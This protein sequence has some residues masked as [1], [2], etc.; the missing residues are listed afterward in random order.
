MT[1]QS[2]QL[3]AIDV[4]A[5]YRGISVLSKVS[6]AARSGRFVAVLGPNGA[7]KSTLIRALAGTLKPSSG[8][9]RFQGKSLM[10]LPR[11]HVARRV[12]VVPQE[13]E[14]AF[15]FRV[16]EV[17]A[18]GR[19]PRQGALMVSDGADRAA[20]QWALEQT[21]LVELVDRPMNALSGGERRRVVLAR[22][23]AQEPEVLLLDEPAAHL[24]LRHTVE[25]YALVHSMTR[26]RGLSCVAVVHDLNAAA[27]WADEAVL[28]NEGKTVAAGT[29]GDAL[30]PDLL[31]D[32]FGVSV[33]M[34]TDA[35]VGLKYFLPVA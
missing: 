10:E 15:G 32:V 11:K 24:D 31:S 7:G 2:P 33:H 28:L 26:S 3:E 25:L 20:V 29:L 27:R 18:M 1:Q 16:G 23:L 19:A 5:G 17:V 34:G 30:T 13:T 14:T 22:A 21:H 35:Q 12:A 9:V 6:L 4:S 8:E